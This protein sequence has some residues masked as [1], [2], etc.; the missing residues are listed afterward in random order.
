MGTISEDAY[1]LVV[2]H[3]STAP[4]PRLIELLSGPLPR[5]PVEKIY[6]QQDSKQVKV[7]RGALSSIG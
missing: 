1:S 5:S 3:V 6:H 7:I 2:H 4:W